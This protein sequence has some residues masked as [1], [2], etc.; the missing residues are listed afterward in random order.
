MIQLRCVLNWQIATATR[1]DV[2]PSRDVC[3]HTLLL[4]LLLSEC[5]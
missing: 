5:C 2:R 1:L 4:L 3:G